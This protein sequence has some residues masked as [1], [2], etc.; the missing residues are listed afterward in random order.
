VVA[1]KEGFEAAASS[2]GVA[3]GSAVAVTLV[4]RPAPSPAPA[5]PRS[6]QDSGGLGWWFWG[7]VIAAG[8]LGAGMAVT[9]GL[10]LRYRDQWEDSDRWDFETRETGL[11]LRTTTDVLLGLACGAVFS[12]IL[13]VF[14][15]DGESDQAPPNGVTALAAPGGI[16]FAW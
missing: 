2:V 5:E 8:T 9:G 11:A 7:S 14:L 16:A 10:A 15:E 12:A 13:A 3:A 1:R 6:G 4:L